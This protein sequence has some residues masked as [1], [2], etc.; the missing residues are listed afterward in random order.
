MAKETALGIAQV[1]IRATLDELEKDLEQARSKI[2]KSMGSVWQ[3]IGGP[4]AKIGTAAVATGLAGIVA[5][6]LAIGGAAWASANKL[7]S[8][9][10]TMIVSTGA[11]GEALEGLKGDFRAVFR[12]FAGDAEV[13]AGIM[14]EVNTRL[15]VTG[16]SLQGLSRPLAET[17]RLIGGDGVRR[18]QLFTRALGDWSVE[19]E[20]ATQTLD[21]FF[22]ASQV[23]GV[24]MDDL[25]AKVVQFGAPMRLMG[26]TLDDSIALFSK[27]E[28]EGVNAELVMGSLRIAAG[29]FAAEGKPLRESLLATF[30]S[31]KNN[32]DASQ[33]LSDA[34]SIFGARAGPDMAAAIREGRFEFDE[35]LAT[36]QDSDGAIL[37]TAAATEDW[38]E[39]LTKLKNRAMIALE[40]LGMAM[41]D[42]AGKALDRLMPALDALI[43]WMQDKIVPALE[44]ITWGVDA[45]ARGFGLLLQGDMG[46]FLELLWNGLYYI[47]EGF[48]FADEQMRPFLDGLENLLWKAKEFVE[49]WLIPFVTEH[50]EAL[51]AALLGIGG[52]IM[53]AMV[54]GAIK[55]LVIA[56]AAINWPIVAVIAAVALLAAAWTQDWGG[57]RTFL[58]NVWENHLQPI[59]SRVAEWLQ[60]KVPQALEFLSNVWENVLLPAIKT[61]WGFFDEYVIPLL[62]AL[63]EVWLATVK[64]GFEVL[65]A[66]WTEVVLPALKDVWQWITDLAAA[67]GEGLTPVLEWLNDKVLGPVTDAFGSLGG[68]VKDVIGWVGGL[69]D[70]IGNLSLPS[71]LTP[72]SPTPFENGLVG[73]SEAMR[74]L[75]A[76]ELPRFQMRLQRGILGSMEVGRMDL[77]AQLLAATAMPVETERRDRD[78]ARQAGVNVTIHQYGEMDANRLSGDLRL[79]GAL[80]R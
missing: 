65:A 25:M 36:L 28:Q 40:P 8:A 48:G 64:L 33:A 70:K 59:L 29:K 16:D 6:T 60:E 19:T 47:G 7:D 74:K 75:S 3:K 24:G 11:T 10:D 4:L 9:F 44:P 78:D 34:M 72:G 31:I 77:N 56:I 46:S 53:G 35:L 45:L 63:A 17:V 54:I 15:D 22:T 51:K 73:I 50:S 18:T 13:L 20:D 49:S 67:I 32:T 41:M 52:V 2:E 68:K 66:L 5:G 14:G 76:T 42:L 23:S 37:A 26:F 55:A 80:G 38:G 69:A 30:E 71:W 58:T 1:P 43:G 61:V 12:D 57:I 21:K 39:K 79:I 62:K 27:W